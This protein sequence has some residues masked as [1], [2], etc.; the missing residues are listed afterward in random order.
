VFIALM[1]AVSPAYAIVTDPVTHFSWLPLTTNV[2]Q[3][4]TFP[5]SYNQAVVT[6]ATPQIPSGYKWATDAQVIKFLS[7]FGFPVLSTANQ[8]VSVKDGGA[9]AANFVG[10]F[11]DTT[12]IPATIG[13]GQPSDFTGPDS[14]DYVR[15]SA[16]QVD[17]SRDFTGAFIS[18]VNYRPDGA[19]IPANQGTFNG[20]FLLVSVPEPGVCSIV[21]VSCLVLAR[22][23][24]RADNPSAETVGA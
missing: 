23:R 11:G 5:L 14:F 3:H 6:P 13:Y 22:D 9:L 1:F 10:L 24:R 17:E 19:Y 12:S 4:Y 7:D 8:S 18:E 15:V 21:L 16:F 2:D 20:G